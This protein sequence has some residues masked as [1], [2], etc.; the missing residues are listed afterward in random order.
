MPRVSRISAESG[1]YHVMLRGINHQQIFEDEED[2]QMFLKIVYNCKKV[3]QFK[4]FAYCLMGNHVHLLIK[5]GKESLEQIFKRIGVRF[6]KWYNLKYQRTGHL[7]QDRFKSEAVEDERY[8]ITVIGYIHQNP[9]K[10]GICKN[11]SEY[12]YSSFLEYTKNAILI[13]ID[14]VEKI[15]PI[16][17][18]INNCSKYIDEQCLEMP[19]KFDY[20]MTDKQAKNIIIEVSGISNPSEFQFLEKNKREILIKKLKNK[21]LSIR[22]ISRLTGI[23]YYVVRKTLSDKNQ[24]QNRP[25]DCSQR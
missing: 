21:G 11:L 17:T 23:T 16:E 20:G 15:V 9:I 19:E 1:I 12:P 4:V 25:G 3:S 22:Q 2:Y 10:A 7:F 13:D 24:S 8:L 14:V 5:K 18:I 6:V